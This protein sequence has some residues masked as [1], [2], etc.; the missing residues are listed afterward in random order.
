[1]I[2][3][4][5]YA[6]AVMT[7][8]MAD[9]M[10]IAKPLLDE[11]DQVAARMTF[12]EAY[13]RIV[14]ANKRNGI[15][16]RWFPSLGHDKEGR[17]PAIAEAVRLGRMG[18]QHA[19]SLSAPDKVASMLQLAGETTL[20]LEHKTPPRDQQ[21]ANLAKIKAMLANSKLSNPVAKKS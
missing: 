16:P 18:A 5:E 1:M 17:E 20:A 9:A 19:I 12:K 4:D 10:R 3:R 2:P 15:K 21:L 6:S 14:D 8:E 13:T 11:G 7:E